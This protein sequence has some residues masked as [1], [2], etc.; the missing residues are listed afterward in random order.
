MHRIDGGS[1]LE[2]RP[3]F[4]N[5]DTGEL[6]VSRIGQKSP[7]PKQDG[8]A[9]A[10]T[11]KGTTMTDTNQVEGFR[12]DEAG[13]V[14]WDNADRTSR[15]AV[16]HDGY[17]ASGNGFRVRVEREFTREIRK[18]A[19]AEA[20]AFRGT[21]VYDVSLN[22]L[23][24]LADREMYVRVQNYIRPR[25]SAKA[26]NEK[27]GNGGWKAT[28][29]SDFQDREWKVADFLPKKKKTVTAA[30]VKAEAK[31]LSTEEKREL[32]EELQAELG[33]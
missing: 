26:P 29:L 13:N 31:T 18:E 5:S 15:L 8:P 23:F 20:Q 16:G 14:M 17:L 4:D 7:T 19:G 33:G 6:A 11:H 12:V 21:L 30:K 10:Y 28:P 2:P 9:L 24:A 32:L 1:R 22:E 3:L 25:L 27:T